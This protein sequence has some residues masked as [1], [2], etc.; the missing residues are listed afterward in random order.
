M[1]TPAVGCGVPPKEVR[2]GERHGDE[3]SAR[4]AR[5]RG[6]RGSAEVTDGILDEGGVV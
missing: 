1:S 4:T 6:V 5:D 2:D 3:K